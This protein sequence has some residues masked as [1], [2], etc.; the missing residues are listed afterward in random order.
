MSEL[1]SITQWFAF[2]EKMLNAFLPILL[3]L[4]FFSIYSLKKS[5]FKEENARQWLLI[6]ILFAVDFTIRF[7]L[8]FAGIPYQG[9]YF[10]VLIILACIIAGAGL[11]PAAKW[12]TSFISRFKTVSFDQALKGLII[13]IALIHVG[14]ALSPPDKKEWLDK[15][16]RLIRE[17]CPPNSQPILISEDADIRIA[18]YAGAKDLRLARLDNPNYLENAEVFVNGK[19]VSELNDGNSESGIEFDPLSEIK[20]KF[21]DKMPY[22]NTSLILYGT[23]LSEAE[24]L[25]LKNDEKESRF[26]PLEQSG[27]N[28]FVFKFRRELSNE[29]CIF[30]RLPPNS[31]C[32]INEIKLVL[33]DKWQILRFGKSFTQ[34]YKFPAVSPQNIIGFK[35]SLRKIGGENVFLLT[36][37]SDTDFRRL[38]ENENVEFPLELVAES[39]DKIKGFFTLYRNRAQ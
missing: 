14:K 17:N 15:I 35:D 1:L 31:R 6:W 16:P 3:V 39:K 26:C 5:F 20:F 18:Y 13:A 38:F 9:R 7:M 22:K 37:M 33:A 27:K 21:Q 25:V 2:L 29:L 28:R 19:K 32:K 24:I 12:L 10:H 23:G 36:R 8:F 11:L 34:G 4:L 30:L